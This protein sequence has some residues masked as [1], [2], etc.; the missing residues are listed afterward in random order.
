MLKPERHEF[1]MRQINLHNR[2]LCSDLVNMMSVSEDT[3]RRDLLELSK[4]GMLY[5]VHGGAISKSYYSSFDYDNVYA[6]D[7]K[8]AIAKKAN[9]LIKDGMVVITGGGSTI[10]ELAKQLPR[11]LKATFYT[12]SP[13][14]AIELAKYE[15]LEIVIL[16]GAFSKNSQIAYGGHVIEQLADIK[17]DLL[18][19]GTSA[20]DANE[21]LTDSDWEI[22]KIKKSLISTARKTAVLCISE[23]LNTVNKLRV[24]YL[25]NIN[26]IITELNPDD[27]MIEPYKSKN[28]YVI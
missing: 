20:I 17:A 15:Y 2:V 24:S 23:K 19:M 6:R 7:S 5:K 22:N 1:I 26:Y 16:G 14:V 8:I 10:L 13:Q 12:I 25:N 18:L 11:N 21:G 28:T 4:I 9:F 27:K 3:I